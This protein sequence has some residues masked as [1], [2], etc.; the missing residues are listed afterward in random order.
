MI[1]SRTKTITVESLRFGISGAFTESETLGDA[2]KYLVEIYN[3][4]PADHRNNARITFD[5]IGGDDWGPDTTVEIFYQRPETEEEIA[6][7]LECLAKEK[8][9]READ[10]RRGEVEQL[11]RL[12]CKYAPHLVGAVSPINKTDGKI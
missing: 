11:R 7:R 12:L 4:I 10:A 1:E 6:S 3:K 9:A 5:S 2:I 8:V